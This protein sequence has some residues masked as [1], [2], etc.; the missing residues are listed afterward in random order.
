MFGPIQLSQI[1]DRQ[2]IDYYGDQLDEEHYAQRYGTIARPRI[3]SR[4]SLWLGKLLIKM[5]EQLTGECH[6]VGL[7]RETA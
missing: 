1:I 7:S 4:F 2:P 3:G 5:G 6:H